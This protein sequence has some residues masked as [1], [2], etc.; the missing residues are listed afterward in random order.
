MLTASVTTQG[1]GIRK[2]TLP[3][4]VVKF[5]SRKQGTKFV[6][7]DHLYARSRELLEH[8]GDLQAHW[9]SGTRNRSSMAVSFWVHRQLCWSGLT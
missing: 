8:Q 9:N 1:H 6:V 3:H 7:K 4:P 5:L 2:P